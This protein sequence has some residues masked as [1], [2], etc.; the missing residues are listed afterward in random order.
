MNAIPRLKG[1]FFWSQIEQVKQYGMNM[2]YVAMFDEVDEGTAIFKC[3]ND[4]PVGNFVTYESL[5]SD[6]Y[7]KLAGKAGRY[8]Q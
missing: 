5:P 8:L 6:Y 1:D 4:P 7:L 2:A 3:T